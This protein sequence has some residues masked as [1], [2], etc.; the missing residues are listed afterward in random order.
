MAC[1]FASLDQTT[2]CEGFIALCFYNELI[3]A[4]RQSVKYEI[5]FV[6]IIDALNKIFP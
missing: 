5:T 4:R 1:L 6:V 2:F 3:F